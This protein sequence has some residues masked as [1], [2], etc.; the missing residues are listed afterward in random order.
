MRYFYVLVAFFCALP[1]FSAEPKS[2]DGVQPTTV[3]ISGP[4]T[5]QLPPAVGPAVIDSIE[6]RLG[7]VEKRLGRLERG[8]KETNRKLD[9][10]LGKIDG[11]LGDKK[12]EKVSL[13]EEREKALKEGAFIACPDG[14]VRQFWRNPESGEL[15]VALPWGDG[16]IWCRV[17]F[18]ATRSGTERREGWHALHGPNW[19]YFLGSGQMQPVVQKLDLLFPSQT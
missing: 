10:L 18:M 3:T 19:E 2:K 6:K 5:V 7:A 4:L 16:A 14:K 17:A 11:F 8:Q 1:C 15:L 13:K 9:F 12:A